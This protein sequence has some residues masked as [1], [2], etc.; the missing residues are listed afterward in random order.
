[1]RGVSQAITALIMIVIA[2]V[3]SL[4]FFLIFSQTVHNSLPKG[5]ILIVSVQ[6]AK[7]V[8]SYLVITVQLTNNGAEQIYLQKA[9][10]M[11]GTIILEEKNITTTDGKTVL[12]PGETKTALLIFNRLNIFPRDLITLIIFYTS[13]NIQQAAGISAIVV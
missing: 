5:S 12:N 2:I 9:R 11:K 3:T 4:L 6:E 7:L 1:M 8:G 13:N 10:L